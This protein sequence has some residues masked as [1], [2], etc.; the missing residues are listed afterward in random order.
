M[1]TSTS[2]LGAID[3]QQSITTCQSVVIDLLAV[4]EGF[5]LVNRDDFS[6]LLYFLKTELLEGD[7]WRSL[8]QD[9]P[10]RQALFFDCYNAI[11]DLS[12]VDVGLSGVNRDGLYFIFSFLHEEL[13]QINQILDCLN[14]ASIN[15]IDKP[16]V[17]LPFVPPEPVQKQNTFYSTAV[18]E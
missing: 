1:P 14:D 5:S 11:N 13:I 7:S 17:N 12:G 10:N 6:F 2:Y 16:E 18:G 8:S 3:R 9:S 4:G 15:K